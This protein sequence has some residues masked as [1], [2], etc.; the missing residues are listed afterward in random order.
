MNWNWPI[1]TK[2][3]NV[4]REKG[5]I[6]FILWFLAIWIGFKLIVVNGIWI[7]MMGGEPFPV[8]RAIGLM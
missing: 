7:F 5:L 8:L 6:Y 4:Y 1:L 2:L 3:R